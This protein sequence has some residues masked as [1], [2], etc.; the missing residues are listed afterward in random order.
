MFFELIAAGDPYFTNIDPAQNNQPYLSQDLRVFGAA[1]AINNTPFP[2]GPAFSDDSVGGAYS[3]HPGAA[4]L[5]ERHADFTNPAGTDPF[6]LLPDQAGEGQ[7][8]TSVAPFALQPALSRRSSSTTTTSPSRGCG[9]AAPS[10]P[11]RVPRPTCGCSSASS[12][13]RAPTPT[14]TRTGPTCRTP[15]RPAIPARRMPGAGD[16][17]IPFFA[18]GN[19]GIQTDYQPGGPNIQTLTIPTGQDKLWWLLRLLPE[20][21]RPGQPSTASRCRRCLPGTHHCIVAQIAYDDAPIPSGVS[22][23]SWDQLAQRN[24]QFT[25]IDNPGPAATHRAPQTFDIRPSKAIGTPGGARA[26]RRT[27]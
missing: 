17:T 13:A 4:R 12:R 8:D 24:L 5:S 10:G 22:P 21:L 27:S 25:V 15:T 18:T 11:T 23:M 6:S 7:T 16:T 26:C 2:G 19:A 1:P 14:S 3:L 20:L 9:C